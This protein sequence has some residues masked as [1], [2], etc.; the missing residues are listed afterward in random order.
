MQTLY[1]VPV[2]ASHCATLALRTGRLVTGE[3]IGLAF[4][5]EA[6]LTETMGPWQQWIRMDLGT[7][8]VMLAPLG[9]VSIRVDAQPAMM[10]PAAA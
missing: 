9:V 6:C 5:S 1:F 2:R 4:T 8:H 3:R 7:L 10:L